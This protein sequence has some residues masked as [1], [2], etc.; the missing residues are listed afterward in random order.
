MTIVGYNS[1]A[2]VI[3][4]IYRPGARYI[5]DIQLRGEPD[6]DAHFL[7]QGNNLIVLPWS[8]FH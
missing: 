8:A 4:T 3:R 5:W 1:A 6:G 7:G 2:E